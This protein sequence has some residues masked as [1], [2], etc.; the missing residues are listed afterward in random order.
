MNHAPDELPASARSA[1]EAYPHLAPSTSF[2]RAVLESLAR[3]RARRKRGLVGRI[4]EFLG[5]GL[6]SFAA[7]GALG[8]FL[9]AAVLGALM[10]SGHSAPPKP[11]KPEVPAALLGWGPFD[12]RRNREYLQ[13]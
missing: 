13:V 8:A 2:N 9:P 7:S 5:L 1:F 3:E 11:T 6:W 4:E 12:L 10:L